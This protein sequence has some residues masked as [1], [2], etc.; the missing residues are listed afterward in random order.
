MWEGA[1]KPRRINKTERKS[2]NCKIRRGR[3]KSFWKCTFDAGKLSE[4]EITHAK[5][6]REEVQ[7]CS[8]IPALEIG[9]LE[10]TVLCQFGVRFWI[11]LGIDHQWCVCCLWPADV[12]K[13]LDGLRLKHLVSCVVAWSFPSCWWSVLRS[14]YNYSCPLINI[15]LLFFVF[16]LAQLGSIAQGMSDNSTV[17]VPFGGCIVFFCLCR[18]MLF[19]WTVLKYFFSVIFIYLML[20]PF[21]IKEIFIPPCIFLSLDTISFQFVI[22]W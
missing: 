22:K 14:E 8:F 13:W 5:E 20:F 4:A 21:M 1:I 3:K 6:T 10:P 18:W 19:I 9:C 17:M 16:M 12:I 15:R 11:S 7:K 2:A